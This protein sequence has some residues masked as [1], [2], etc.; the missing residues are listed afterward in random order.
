MTPAAFAT[1][2]NQ[3][4]CAALELSAYVQDFD[5][6][7]LLYVKWYLNPRGEPDEV[8]RLEQGLRLNSENLLSREPASW[9]LFSAEGGLLSAPGVYRV[10]LL[11]ADA[12]LIGRVPVNDTFTLSDGGTV[13]NPRYTDSATWLIEVQ[14]RGCP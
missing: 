1:T 3:P 9:R 12:P 2:G 7:E 10:E 5:D 11:V 6:E 8:A 13:E 14:D 4:G